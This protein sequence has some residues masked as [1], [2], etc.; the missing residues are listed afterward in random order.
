MNTQKIAITVPM[1]LLTVL[2]DVRKHRGISRSKFISEAVHEKILKEQKQ[3]T[4]GNYDSETDPWDALDIEAVAVE[5][6]RTDGSVNHDFY[7]YGI[8]K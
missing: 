4:M 7:I 3:V 5:T 6:G 2:D 8:L 1:P